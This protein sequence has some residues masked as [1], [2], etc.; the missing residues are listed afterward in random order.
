MCLCAIRTYKRAERCSYCSKKRL[1]TWQNI[2][3]IE[4]SRI[5]Q[6]IKA[7]ADASS[8]EEYAL[9][10]TFRLEVHLLRPWAKTLT[11]IA[12][13]GPE[14][15]YLLVSSGGEQGERPQLISKPEPS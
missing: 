12:H 2:R 11:E 14:E 7:D 9:G 8:V 3:L 15:A 5:S 1:Q 6:V 13:G 10:R 4:W